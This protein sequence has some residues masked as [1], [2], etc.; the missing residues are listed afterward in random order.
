LPSNSAESAVSRRSVPAEIALQQNDVVVSGI[1][2]RYTHQPCTAA[3]P[4][5]PPLLMLHGLLGYSFCWRRNLPELSRYAEIY[6]PDLPGAGFSDRPQA[7]QPTLP[8]FARLVAEF[9]E[10][11]GLQ[12]IDLL[13]T[14]HGAAV[15]MLLASQTG[16][17]RR[18]VLNAPVNPWSSGNQRRIAR[19]STLP[20]ALALRAIY[21]LLLR[22]GEYFLGQLYCDPQRIPADAV[23]GYVAAL[24]TPGTAKFLLRMLPDWCADLEA[25]KSALGKISAIP[26]LLVWGEADHAIAL[27]SAR[28]LERCFQQAQVHVIANSGH[29]PYEET[30]DEFNRLVIEFLYRNGSGL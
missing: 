26:T 27:A 7:F 30:P 2:L 15:A 17:V 18:L 10:A 3:T 16:Y 21:P 5:G 13:G 20:G 12:Q 28:P 9:C 19:F 24:R 1:R 8:Q 29:M 23:A 6:A 11:L 4:S 14:S 25:L 22:R